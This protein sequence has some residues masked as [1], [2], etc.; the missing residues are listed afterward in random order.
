[1]VGPQQAR[2]HRV[3]MHIIAHGLKIAVA[4]AID[5]ERFVA[6]AKDMSEFQVSSIEAAGVSA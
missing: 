3:E 5:D 4:A 2:S 6:T 1:V